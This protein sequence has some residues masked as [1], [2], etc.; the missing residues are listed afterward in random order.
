MIRIFRIPRLAIAAFALAMVVSCDNPVCGCLTPARALLYGR[1]TNPAGGGV[2]G[3]L[4]L[5]EQGRGTCE[6][7]FFDVL[8]TGQTQA[9]GRYR[10]LLRT[11]D[12]PADDE[13]LR[14]YARPA[15][16]VGTLIGSDSVEFDVSF[17]VDAPLDSVRVD[18]VLREP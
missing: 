15:P 1:V 8:S 3:A 4:V 17:K 11:G 7:D 14:A 12:P 6:E 2:A 9:D 18:L 13:C 5:A 16:S 10:L